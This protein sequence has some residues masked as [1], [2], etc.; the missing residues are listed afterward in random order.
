MKKLEE[1][2]GVPCMNL[3]H[4]A[5]RWDCTQRG[6]QPLS[7]G[8]CPMTLHPPTHKERLTTP[9]HMTVHLLPLLSIPG[10]LS[11]LSHLMPAISCRLCDIVTKPQQELKDLGGGAVYNGLSVCVCA[12]SLAHVHWN[13]REKE[14]NAVIDSESEE[15]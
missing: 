8:L 12:C 6:N 2:E 5:N 9:S 10:H 3:T 7:E 4:P 15:R 13:R 14:T 11:R 1:Q